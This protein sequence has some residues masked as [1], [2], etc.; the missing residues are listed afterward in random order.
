MRNQILTSIDIHK[1]SQSY[2]CAYFKLLHGVGNMLCLIVLKRVVRVVTTV[3]W[4]VVLVVTT[5]IWH[6]VRV[7]TTVIWH[8]VRVVTTMIWR[9]KW[10]WN[11]LEDFAHVLHQNRVY[12]RSLCGHLLGG[13]DIWKTK[14]LVNGDR[15]SLVY[16]CNGLLRLL[17]PFYKVVTFISMYTTINVTGGPC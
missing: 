3:I 11:R 6:V 1:N 7:V 5:V 12:F 10:K 13:D 2:S 15:W 8:V 9:D 4:H 17:P 14:M 16:T